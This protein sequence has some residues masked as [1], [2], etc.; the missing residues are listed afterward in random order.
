MAIAHIQGNVFQTFT[1]AATTPVTLGSTV[2]VGNAIVGSVTAADTVTLTSVTDDKSNTYTILDSHDLAANDISYTFCL[3][4]ITNGP[5][6]ITANWSSSASGHNAI[7][8]DEYSGVIAN[9]NPI[10]NS[11]AAHVGNFQAAP[12]TGTDGA[13]ST[14]VTTITNGCMIWGSTANLAGDS[15]PATAGTG[16]TPRQAASIK[17]LTEDLLQS[18]AGSIAATFTLSTSQGEFTALIAL[19]PIGSATVPVGIIGLASAEW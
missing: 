11:G 13:T 9:T 19:Q 1:A 16:F 12:G 14:A 5:K 8:V 18:T 7:L 2:G 6:T 4:N 17:G 10:D 3:G 15:N